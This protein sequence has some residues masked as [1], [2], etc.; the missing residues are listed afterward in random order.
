MTQINSKLLG[1]SKPKSKWQKPDLLAI[2]GFNKKPG[3]RYRLIKSSE[4]SSFISGKDHRGWEIVKR[5]AGAQDPEETFTGSLS[6]FSRKALGSVYKLGDL[7]LAR[8]P[9]E[10]AK[11]RTEYYS[12]RSRAQATQDPKSKISRDLK[13]GFYT[14]DEL[15]KDFKIAKRQVN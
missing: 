6:Q 5:G 12:Q 8:M 4:N 9:E 7:I 11:Q 2:S 10:H 13:T 15:S 1:T 3:Y 14:E